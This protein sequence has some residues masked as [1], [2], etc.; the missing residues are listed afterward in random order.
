MSWRTPILDKT[1]TAGAAISAYRF[2]KPGSA[3]GQVLVAA[4]AT[5]A[6]IGVS[7]QVGAAA[8]G[9]SIDICLVGIAE[10][11][12]GGN[13][14]RGNSLTADSTGRAV[15]ASTGNII[16]GKALMS[17][18]ENDIIPILVHAAGDSDAAPLLYADL[19]V[20][21]A[22]LLALFTTPL[23]LVAAPGA[24]KAVVPVMA[25]AFLDAG[26][27]AYDGIASGEDLVLRY[28]D[29]SGAI[30]LTIET[31]GFLD[32]ASDQQRVVHG[33]ATA[34]APAANAAL[35]LHMST[36]NIATGNGTL[37]VRVWYRILD[38]LS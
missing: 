28:T 5:D 34:Y 13:V 22:Q 32:Q 19:A 14:T 1:Q 2:V 6:I 30:A 15:V 9:E 20:T 4:A 10:V 18:V 16:G 24:G 35:M 12:C 17:G 29:A 26:A 37:K 8:A 23:S 7:G 3:D 33:P 25:Q 36:G 27:T 11:V 21:S 38:T 31:T